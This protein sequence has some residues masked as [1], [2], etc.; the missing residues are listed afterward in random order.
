MD[1]KWLTINNAFANI[2]GYNDPNEL[3]NIGVREIYVSPW[4]R[5]KLLQILK[6]TERVENYR[7][8]LRKKDGS[9]AIVKLNNRLVKTDI[10]NEYLEGNIS[11]ITAQVKAEEQRNE[12][13]IALKL[14]K[15]KS[16]RLA[17]EA[18]EFSELKSKFLANMSHEIRTPINGVLGF[19]TL[20][21]NGAYRDTEEL[22]HYS[23]NAR[24][25]SESLLEI[26][27]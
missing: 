17:K 21:E 4:E 1:G 27:N 26:I 10:G 2:L 25:S 24:Q 22:K 7:I 13:E 14:E 3:L 8:R 23:S 20:I 9:V 12:A 19:L 18:I 11:D 5:D 15:E 16:E 6:S